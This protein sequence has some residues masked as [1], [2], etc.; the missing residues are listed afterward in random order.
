MHPQRL[1]NMKLKIAI[2]S[3]IWPETV[4]RLKAVHDCRVAFNPA[5]TEKQRVLAEAEVAVIRSPVKLDSAAIDAAPRLRLIIR[6]GAGLEGID[7]DYAR[8]RSI[9]VVLEPLS[10]ESV[11]EHVFGL[12]LSVAHRIPHHHAALRAGR[13][14]KHGGFGWDLRGRALGLVGFG[15]IGMRTAEIAQVFG[16]TLAA[17]DRSPEKPQKQAAAARLGVRFISLEDLL[18]ESDFVSFHVPLTED[19]RGLMDARRLALMKPGAVL[20]NVGRGGIVCETALNAALRS[21]H[22]GGAAL[23]VFAQEPPG[24]NPLFELE[25]F[26]GTPHVAAQTIDAQREIGE[27]VE[28]II[29]KF[30]NSEPLDHL[31]ILP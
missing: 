28:R 14:E 13:W 17:S 6:A 22:L 23:D 25:N 3:Q 10:A 21:G 16:M 24:V 31:G 26:V 2:L 9:A 4:A 5:P 20:I 30:H 27:S 1:V 7:L 8:K 19:T 29:A 15:R 12:I 18:R 11:A